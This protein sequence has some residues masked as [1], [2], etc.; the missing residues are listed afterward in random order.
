MDDTGIRQLLILLVLLLFLF[1]PSIIALSKNHPHKIPI[2]LFNIFCSIFL[3][4]GWF[5]ALVWSFILPNNSSSSR[6]GNTFSSADEIRKLHELKEQGVIT[7][8]EFE[9]QKAAL[10]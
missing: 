9:S 8:E 4:L 5:I 10:L 6:S 3:W 2:I 1:L 7:Q